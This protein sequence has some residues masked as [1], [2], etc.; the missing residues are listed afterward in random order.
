MNTHISCN[1]RRANTPATY[2]VILGG[3]GVS[4]RL[5][6]HS[7]RQIYSRDALITDASWVIEIC[8]P[9]GVSAHFI[10][11]W[12]IIGTCSADPGIPRD[13]CIFTRV[14]TF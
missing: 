9:T 3:K 6:A 11:D 4:T 14:Y 8:I 12:R 13:I 1:R 5:D 7:V 10:I 2:S